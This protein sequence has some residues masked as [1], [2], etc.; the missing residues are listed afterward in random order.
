[1]EALT[2]DEEILGNHFRCLSVGRSASM[3]AVKLSS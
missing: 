3:V 2:S 1:L